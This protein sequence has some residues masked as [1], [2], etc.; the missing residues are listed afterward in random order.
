M[1]IHCISEQANASL[2]PSATRSL[3]KEEKAVFMSCCRHLPMSSESSVLTLLAPGLLGP[4]PDLIRM[5]D[6]DRPL[7]PHLRRLLSRA[8]WQTQDRQDWLEKLFRLFGFEPAICC[9]PPVAAI[10][11][12][13]DGLDAEAGVWLRADP[14][15]LKIDMDR[16]LMSD[17]DE[18][19]LQNKEAEALLATL[20]GHFAEDGLRFEMGDASR[21]Y[22]QLASPANMLATDIYRVRG[23]NVLAFLPGG[24]EAQ[25]WRHVL[26][27]MQMLLHSHEVNLQ[28]ETTGRQTVNSV[29]FWG[30]GCLPEKP[31]T[32]AW[33]RV[34]SDDALVQSLAGFCAIPCSPLAEFSSS[35]VTGRQLLVID[36]FALPAITNDVYV[37]SGLIAQYD[38]ALFKGLEQTLRHNKTFTLAIDALDGR[39]ARITRKQ[40][41]RWWRR[42]KSL[43]NLI[44]NH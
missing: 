37:W 2:K 25:K 24:E 5:P 31:A 36:D 16:A 9:Q 18:L 43:P 11:A 3:P 44:T 27:E 13:Q 7:S 21:W 30:Q 4:Q 20:N 41:R 6:E 17:S 12:R 22:V 14:V 19:Q 26:N 23:Q 1:E 38:H 42:S 15:H 32:K 40:M 33:E 28:R 39:L 10:T 35:D 8:S 34:F 29:W